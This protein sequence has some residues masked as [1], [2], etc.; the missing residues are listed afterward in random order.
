MND[1]DYVYWDSLLNQQAL[2]DVN[3]F[4][5]SNYDS[6]ETNTSQA[7]D[8][9][10]QNKKKANTKLITLGKIAPYVNHC[11]DQAYLA[12]ARAYGYNIYPRNGLDTF[13]HAVYGEEDSGK[14]DFHYDGSRS[15]IYDIKL[16][17]I[18][19]VSLKPYEGGKF[20]IFNNDEYEIEKFVKPGSAILFKSHLNHRVTPV[21]KGERR[22]LTSFLCGPK[23]R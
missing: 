12:A 10:G 22:S 20:K 17:F 21:T 23:F 1:T 14:Y 18:I 5:E 19:N 2:I 11:L 8:P 15:D 3:N 13:L 6:I 9:N 7:T 16:T 4:I